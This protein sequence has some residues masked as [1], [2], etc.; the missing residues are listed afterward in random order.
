[1]WSLVGWK[2]WKSHE[3]QLTKGEVEERELEDSSDGA[4]VSI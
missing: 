2:G 4:R 3:A 1:M